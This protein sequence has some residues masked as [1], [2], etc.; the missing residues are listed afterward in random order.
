MS[1]IA[2]I[3][4]VLNAYMTFKKSKHIVSLAILRF[5]QPIRAADTV[6]YVCKYVDGISQNQQSASPY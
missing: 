4:K 5:L 1:P 2:V 6:E 3:L